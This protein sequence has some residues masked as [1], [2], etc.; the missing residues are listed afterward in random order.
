MAISDGFPFST[1]I[2]WAAKSCS[3]FELQNLTFLEA[4]FHLHLDRRA[5]PKE[6][7]RTRIIYASVLHCS[8]S[9]MRISCDS[10]A[11]AYGIWCNARRKARKLLGS[12]LRVAWKSLEVTDSCKAHCSEATLEVLNLGVNKKLTSKKVA[13]VHP[14]YTMLG[15]AHNFGHGTS[16]YGE[17]RVGQRCRFVACHIMWLTL[18]GSICDSWRTV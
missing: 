14:H 2:R 13:N 4:L 8:T 9:S 18:W 3:N 7:Y 17:E 11:V 12:C 1:C 5:T 15:I 6:V 16:D 10:L